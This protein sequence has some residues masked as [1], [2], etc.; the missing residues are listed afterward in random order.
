MDG[1][2][3]D[4]RTG[5]PLQMVEI[6]EPVRILFVIETT[7][8]LLEK[9]LA[10]NPTVNEFVTNRWIRVAVMDPETGRIQIRR[11]HGYEDTPGAPPPLPDSLLT[12]GFTTERRWRAARCPWLHADERV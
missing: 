3:S 12:Y 1:Q 11:D 5:L 8:A 2:G 6:H 4:V 7:P 9:V 10:G